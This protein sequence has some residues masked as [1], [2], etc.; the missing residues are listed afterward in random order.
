[1][2]K[3]FFILSLLIIE[4]NCLAQENTLLWS[5]SGNGLK[6]TSYLYGTIHLICAEDFILKEKVERSFTK[7][8]ELF[9]ELDMDDEKEMEIMLSSINGDE[10]LSE[11]LTKKQQKKLDK[12][13][14]KELGTSLEMVDQYSLTTIS[15]L[16]LVKAMN[17]TE[18]KSYEQVFMEMANKKGIEI[19]GLEKVT[20]QIECLKKGESKEESFE[21]IFDTETVETLREVISAYGDENLSD[22]KALFSDSTYMDENTKEWLLNVRNENWVDKMPKIMKAKPAFFAIGA[23][24]LI[25]DKGLISLLRKEGYNVSPVKN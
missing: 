5:V 22:L 20:F 1:M 23:A 12:K 18:T 8:D 13:L 21:N 24:H 14:N 11:I 17:C 3:I 25:G 4:S 15:T 7:C 10:K 6:D 2:K 9:L 16:F 19:K